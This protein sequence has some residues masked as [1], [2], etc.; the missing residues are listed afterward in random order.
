MNFTLGDV[1]K[2]ILTSVVM[3]KGYEFATAN[4]YLK[5]STEVKT[6]D[7]LFYITIGFPI[8]FI[9]KNYIYEKV[10]MKLQD[11]VIYR[12]IRK[13]ERFLN[14][15]NY[16]TYLHKVHKVPKKETQNT[17]QKI[18]YYK[19]GKDSHF[20]KNNMIAISIH[21]FYISGTIFIF[22]TLISIGNSYFL[23]WGTYPNFLILLFLSLVSFSLGFRADKKYE[24]DELSMLRQ[25]LKEKEIEDF[26]NKKQDYS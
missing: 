8:Y 1:I 12:K 5:F 18:L 23:N 9:Y 13:G 21:F 10:L 24:K 6:A 2:Y 4:M 25:K 19:L 22:L 11:W 14:H 17:Y 7:L 26:I 3:M 16:R 20:D 15:H